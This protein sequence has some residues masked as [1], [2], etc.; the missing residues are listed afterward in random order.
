MSPLMIKQTHLKHAL[1][2]KLP[3]LRPKIDL[4]KLPNGPRT[5]KPPPL[6]LMVN[7]LE[8]ALL[9]HKLKLMPRHSKLLTLQ[10]LLRPIKLTKLPLL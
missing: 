3:L 8:V 1:M 6:P 4:T 7:G 5:P 2:P 10:M 9:K